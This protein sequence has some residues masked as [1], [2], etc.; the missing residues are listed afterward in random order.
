NMARIG[1]SPNSRKNNYRN[2]DAVEKVIR[3]VFDCKKTPN[4]IIGALGATITDTDL[5]INQF[6]KVQEYYHKRKGKRI[7]HFYIS[8]SNEE[9]ERFIL[10]DY[11]QIGYYIADYF[12]DEYQVAFALHENTTHYHI[13]FVVNPVNCKT[14]KKYHWQWSDTYKIKQILKCFI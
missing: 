13:H 3:Y 1:F 9:M 14:G 7:I 10:E 5:M 8:F 12:S 6:L 2:D 4:A 11:R